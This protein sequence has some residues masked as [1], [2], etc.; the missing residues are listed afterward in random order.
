MNFTLSISQFLNRSLPC[1]KSPEALYAPDIKFQ[2]G[3]AAAA[4]RWRY[5][6]VLAVATLDKLE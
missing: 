4:G 3:V 1:L 5:K 2:I 6:R